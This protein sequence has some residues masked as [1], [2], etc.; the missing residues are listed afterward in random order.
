[1]AVLAYPGGP[2]EAS[3]RVVWDIRH[4]LSWAASACRSAE[5]A[6]RAARPGWA[7]T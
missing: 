3:A 4:G 1:M 5:M 6:I 7:R 2:A